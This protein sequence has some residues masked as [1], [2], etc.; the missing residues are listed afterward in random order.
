H[1]ILEM[2][3][4][5]APRIG[6]IAHHHARPLA[7]AHGRSPAVGQQINIHITR[8]QQECIIAR[9][10]NCL[11]S[12]L[13]TDDSHRFYHFDLVGLRPG[14][15]FL[16]SHWYSL[17]LLSYLE[18]ARWIKHTEYEDTLKAFNQTISTAIGR[19]PPL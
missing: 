5:F 12:L 1:R 19:R 14:S 3:K 17:F 18:Y 10:L 15:V 8:S 16:F 6:F 11:F 2:V 7:V 9:L 13:P 4:I